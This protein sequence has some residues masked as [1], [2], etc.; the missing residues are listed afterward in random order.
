MELPTY[1]ELCHPTVQALRVLG[2][3]ASNEKIAE[4]V[5]RGLQIPR[6]LIQQPHRD[7]RYTE[8]EYRLA[9]ARSTL[10]ACGLINNPK[11]AVWEMTEKGSRYATNGPDEVVNLLAQRD[12]PDASKEPLYSYDDDPVEDELWYGMVSEQFLAGYDEADSVY[13]EYR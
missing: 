7:G 12:T 9:W 10:K 1:L 11:D 3:R 5:V 8:L 4:T 2:G 13:D 6:T